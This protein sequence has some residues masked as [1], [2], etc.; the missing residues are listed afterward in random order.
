MAFGRWQWSVSENPGN[1]A[2]ILRELRV[3][4]GCLNPTRLKFFTGATFSPVETFTSGWTSAP[5]RT[6][7]GDETAV[8][9]FR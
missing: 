2:D 5:L 4:S 9:S 7:I 8:S 1:L 6:F 3:A